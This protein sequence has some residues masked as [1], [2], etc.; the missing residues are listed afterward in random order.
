M[1]VITIQTN[2]TASQAIRAALDAANDLLFTVTPTSDVEFTAR[3]G[4]FGLSIIVGAFVCYC[5]FKLTAVSEGEKTTVHLERNTP[6]WTG[7]IGIRRV[8]SQAKDLAERIKLYVEDDG[9]Q[10]IIRE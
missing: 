10:A 3:K 6:W 5:R 2:R 8:K 7:M 9:G 1:P 4:N